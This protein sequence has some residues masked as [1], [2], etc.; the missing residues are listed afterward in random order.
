MARARSGR[1]GTVSATAM[2]RAPWLVSPVFDL[3]FLANWTWP[4]LV[5]LVVVTAQRPQE[6]GFLTHPGLSF[7]QI[8]FL[9][10]PHRWITLALVFMDGDRFR[11][12]AVAYSG[13]GV[14]TL[15]GVG[16]VW[17]GTGTLAL[18]VLGDYLWNAWH[19]ASQHSGVARIY[20]RA[21]NPGAPG[22][23][24]FE[25]IA[26][27]VFVLYAIF[28][29]PLWA[30]PSI[31]PTFED[32]G[33]SPAWVLSVVLSFYE[34]LERLAILALDLD[35]LV[36]ILPVALLVVELARAGRGTVGRLAYLASVCVL[37]ASLIVGI[38]SGADNRVLL[39]L[40]L[41]ISIFH[42]TEYLAIVSWSVWKRHG[43]GPSTLFGSLVPRWGL[44][45]LAFMA[46]LAVTAWMMDRNYLRAWMVVTIVVSYLHYA[47]DGMI[48][49][50]RRPASA[51]V[52]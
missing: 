29:L 44:V 9:T 27:R 2:A 14:A 51:A 28:R 26:L 31:Y 35:P 21:S 4:L 12:R 5:L 47:Y 52:A 33:S 46:V 16:V 40:F 34:G 11:Q 7:W 13:V 32:I 15:V 39:G 8:Y 17:L 50:V 38:R 42:A 30:L 3:A 43:R 22:G 37:Y 18:L 23:A 49:K 48:W 25:K 10:T 45:L 19:Y 36:L 1:R 20:G 41:A 24:W 6:G